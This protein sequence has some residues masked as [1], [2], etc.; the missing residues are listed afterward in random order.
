MIEE[1]R[2]RF[3]TELLE[4]ASH[5]TDL[6]AHKSPSGRY[7]LGSGWRRSGKRGMGFRYVIRQQDAE[8]DL[9]IY[10]PK[11]SD[12]RNVA[13]FDYFAARKDEIESKFGRNLWWRRLEDKRACRIVAPISQGGLRDEDRW[14]DIQ[15]AMID[16]MIRLEKALKPHIEKLPV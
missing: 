3:W 15:D 14:P 5:K 16:N 1:I 13:V 4:R 7:Y 10:D 2:N 6:H 12:E 8:V 11:A 9:Y